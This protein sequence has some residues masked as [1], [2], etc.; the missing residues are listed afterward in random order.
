MSEVDK[1]MEIFPTMVKYFIAAGKNTAF[2]TEIIA[3]IIHI[4]TN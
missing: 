4:L 2:L 3:K 1:Y